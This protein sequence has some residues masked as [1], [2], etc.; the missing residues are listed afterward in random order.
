ARRI[1]QGLILSSLHFPRDSLTKNH[2]AKKKL[3]VS[4]ASFTRGICLAPRITR[5]VR[6]AART[7]RVL[8]AAAWSVTDDYQRR[9]DAHRIRVQPEAGDHR[10]AR[11][12]RERTAAG[13]GGRRRA[14]E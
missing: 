6:A 12:P 9:D 3:L 2:C 14:S 10:G 1:P 4:C 7:R 8:R 13:D 11:G 5:V